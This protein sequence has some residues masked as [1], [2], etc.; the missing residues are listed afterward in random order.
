[1]TTAT[2]FSKYIRFPG[3]KKNVLGAARNPAIKED[4][5]LLRPGTG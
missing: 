4:S 1:M 5:A 2:L 3:I